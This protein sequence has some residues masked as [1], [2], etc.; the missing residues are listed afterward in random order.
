MA[1]KGERIAEEETKCQHMADLAQHDLDEA[2]PA[3]QEAIKVSTGHSDLMGRVGHSDL[4]VMV[5]GHSDLEGMVT[6]HSDL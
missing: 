3:L 4:Q 6:G 1:Q 2:L 5:T